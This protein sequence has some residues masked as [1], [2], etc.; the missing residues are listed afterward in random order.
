MK[1]KTVYFGRENGMTA[2][3]NAY[4]EDGWA[5]RTMMENISAKFRYGSST[6]GI[7][8]VFERQVSEDD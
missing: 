6:V 8:V 7:W 4:E 3:I 1:T 2:L 5:V